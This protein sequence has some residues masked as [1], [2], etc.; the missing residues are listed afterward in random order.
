MKKYRKYACFCIWGVFLVYL[1][2]QHSLVWM[3][4]DD[5]GYA[6]LSYAVEVGTKGNNYSFID[7]INYLYLHYT[8]WG[9]R[10]LFYGIAILVYHYG[11]LIGIRL[12]QSLI[13]FFIFV[14][15]GYITKKHLNRSASGLIALVVCSLYGVFQVELVN[16]GIYWFSAASGYVW[17]MLILI[18]VSYRQYDLLQTKDFSKRKWMLTAFL[19]FIAAFSQE[20][21]AVASVVICVSLMIYHFATVKQHLF[22]S[23]INIMMC[24][25]GAL[26]MLCAPGNMV[27]LVD[28]SEKNIFQQMGYNIPYLIEYVLIPNSKI[29][30]LLVFLCFIV[31][32]KNLY[33]DNRFVS[34]KYSGAT[35]IVLK[36]Y[37]VLQM[38]LITCLIFDYTV[39]RRFS[40]IYMMIMIVIGCM[41]MGIYLLLSKKVYHFICMLGAICCYGA[42]AIVPAIPVRIMIPFM[43]LM[44][45][46]ISIILLEFFNND[47]RV[48]CI[49]VVVIL[50]INLC[51]I[52]N[53]Y[54][55]NQPIQKDNW[56]HLSESSVLFQNG[57]EVNRIELKK[58]KNPIY[59]GP[60]SY[61]EAYQWSDVLIKNYF[62]LPMNVELVW[63]DS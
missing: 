61:M 46:P 50:L 35:K 49:P 41:I 62:D 10:I 23:A 32:A 51:S 39:F 43:L 56:E 17:P 53:G 26:I 16:S 18:F 30:L 2:V 54:M 13:I 31:V 57:G 52:Y 34:S 8:K 29:F 20:Q 22:Y 4:I 5:F 24:L 36:C 44:L 12:F 19:W 55:T 7:I 9:G 58:L 6:T 38:V 11:G 45:V 48:F 33:E 21:I 60:M 37:I 15:M 28:S 14:L 42:M 25:G 63:E 1:F 47:L 27:R 59:S 3:Y 40:N